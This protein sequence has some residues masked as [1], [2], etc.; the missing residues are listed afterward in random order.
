MG[1]DVLVDISDEV[2][3]C[4]APRDLLFLLRQIP[5]FVANRYQALKANFRCVM[6]TLLGKLDVFWTAENSG[7]AA[8]TLHSARPFKGRLLHAGV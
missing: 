2:V 3:V 7:I 1:N 5:A 8:C 6:S 4:K